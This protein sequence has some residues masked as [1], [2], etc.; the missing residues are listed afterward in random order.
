VQCEHI[1]QRLREFIWLKHCKSK[2]QAV[3]LRTRWVSRTGYFP[4]RQLVRETSTAQRLNV[5]LGEP[6][7]R[8]AAE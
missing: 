4:T 7:R 5:A 3:V 8:N 2:R 6:W 1:A